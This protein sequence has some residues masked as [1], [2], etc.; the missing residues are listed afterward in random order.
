[1]KRLAKRAEPLISLFAAFFTQNLVS[2]FTSSRVRVR[3]AQLTLVA[4]FVGKGGLNFFYS[5]SV[6]HIR[7]QNNL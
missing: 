4:L 1:V 3:S 5:T 6:L 7:Q 2:P